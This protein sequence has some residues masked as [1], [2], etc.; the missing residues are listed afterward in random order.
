MAMLA[1]FAVCSAHGRSDRCVGVAVQHLGCV[2][3]MSRSVACNSGR[4]VSSFRRC[5]AASVLLLESRIV[6]W[7]IN[8]AVGC[9]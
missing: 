2:A 8:I 7:K 6:V 4:R 9:V 1:M 5:L 3:S